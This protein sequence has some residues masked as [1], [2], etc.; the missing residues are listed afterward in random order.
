M[1]VSLRRIAAMAF[2]L[3]ALTTGVASAQNGTVSGRIT[4][5]DG[6]RPVVGVTVRALTPTNA[7][8]AATVSNDDGQYR[9]SVSAGTYTISARRV[10]Y[11][12]TEQRDVVV[13]AGGTAE[14][15]LAMTAVAVELNVNVVTAGRVEQK[16]LEADAHTEVVTAKV[17]EERPTLT[18]VEQ[19]RSVPGVDYAGTGIQGGNVVVRGFNNV[20]SGAMLTISDYR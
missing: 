12:A 3:L 7:T 17:V 1:V 9:L 18:A 11:A 19:L 13:S 20:F 2:A 6:G 8:A 14:A 5:V 4:D 10:G 15:N 16:A